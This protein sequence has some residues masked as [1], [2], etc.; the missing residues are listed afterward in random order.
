MV[1]LYLIFPKTNNVMTVKYSSIRLEN[2]IDCYLT[3]IHT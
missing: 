3:Y 2:V 1:V